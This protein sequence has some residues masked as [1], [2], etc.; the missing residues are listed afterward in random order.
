LHGEASDAAGGPVNQH[1]LAGCEAARGEKGLPGG[2]ARERE[3]RRVYVVDRPRLQRDLGLPD[4]DEFGIGPVPGDVGAA[5][6]LVADLQP[7]GAGSKGLDN[8]RR[9]P[10]EHQRKGV[11]QHLLELPLADL[12]VHRVYSGGVHAHEHLAV[13]W[14]GARRVLVDEGLRPAVGVDAHCLHGLHVGE[15]PRPLE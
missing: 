13:A 8:A 14:M 2:Q 5:E 3:G 11:V 6:H 7:A 12:P 4:H 10:S 15:R 1:P 9:V